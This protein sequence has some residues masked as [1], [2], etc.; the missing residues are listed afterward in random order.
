MAAGQ[1][2]TN[3]KSDI[4]TNTPKCLEEIQQQESLNALRAQ[5]LT[6]AAF[7]HQPVA[8]QQA[9]R[10]EQFLPIP[11]TAQGVDMHL[12]GA[13]SLNYLN[14]LQPQPTAS[15]AAFGQTTVQY[16]GRVRGFGQQGR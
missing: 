6:L 11:A 16:R 12:P 4:F 1:R 13:T 7:Q 3:L 10:V 14:Q 8:P 9:Q 5:A 2:L 15:L